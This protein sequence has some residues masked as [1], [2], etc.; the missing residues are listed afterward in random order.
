MKTIKKY[1]LSVIILL[2]SL[3]SCTD[4][5]EDVYDLLTED[6]F[7]ENFSDEDLV[8]ALGSVYS[9]M[10]GLVAGLQLHVKGCWLY[11]GEESSDLWITPKRGG[12]WYDGG[13]YFR[14]NQHT[15][16]VDHQHFKNVWRTFYKG[17]NNCNR[18]IYQFSERDFENKDGVM[19]EIR[20][21]RAFWYYHLIDFFGNVPLETQYD[22]PA[23]YLPA[24]N[25]REDVFNFIV[26]EL[27]E[28]IPYLA[29]TGYSR[30]NKY[31]AM[32]L[33][34][35][36]YLNAEVWADTEKWDNV[37]SLCDS[38]ME[39]G[40]YSLDPDYSTPFCVD[41]DIASKEIILALVN[42]EV[43]TPWGDAFHIHMWTHH[44]RYHYHAETETFF[45]GGFCAPPE[46]IDTYDSTDIRLKK[47]WM[48]GQLYDNLGTLTGV[49]GKPMT[50]APW[51][52]RDQ[53]KP[54]IYTKE[55][56]FDADGVTSGE[57][58][59]MRAIKYEIPKGALNT[60]GNDF[61]Y[62]RYA[63]VFFMK[64]EALWRKNNK[65]ATQEVVDLINDVRKRAFIDFS[66]D[67]VLTVAQL[68]EDRFLNEYAWE[69]CVEGHRR[70]Q[71]IRFGQ[72]TTKTW[73][74][75]NQPSEEYRNLFPIPY[76]E[77]I[78]NT[79]LEQNPGY[80]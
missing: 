36:V 50:C 13:I 4:L 73:I 19:A 32:H 79:N 62:F 72:Y 64:A 37:A 22:V 49:V 60:M 10:R 70:Q 51:N 54:L 80:N 21:A 39:S 38:I 14:L 56:V 28:S 29:E 77:L 63:D 48:E 75:K 27:E 6:K 78:S 35:R 47:T 5:N 24:T 1:F 55:I 16:A 53:G 61:P 74:M 23:G 42:D 46:F 71:L 17:V 31:A 40:H 58:D 8:G 33:L 2:V 43:Y 45:W 69:F 44:G 65:V 52:P 20:V 11:T 12:A 68:D 66:G 3:N 34:A 41:N 67:K 25:S 15:W 30:W 18:L 26:D 7:Y 57:R 59:G 9:D 76:E